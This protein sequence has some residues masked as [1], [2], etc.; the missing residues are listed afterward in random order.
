MMRREPARAHAAVFV[1]LATFL[2]VAVTACQPLTPATFVSLSGS[3]VRVEA[4]RAGG[5][6]HLGTGI[7]IAP[8]IIVT[9]CHV[10][11]DGTGIRIVGSGS[12]WDVTG[13]YADTLHDLCFLR[14]PE[15]K[16]SPVVLGTSEALHLGQ[17]VAALGFTGG[18]DIALKFGRVLALHSFDAGEVI[19]SDTAFTSGSSGGGLFD[20]GGALVGLLTFRSRGSSSSYYSVPVE[21]I[22]ERLPEESQWTEL[23][24]LDGAAPFWQG[25][26]ETLPYFLRVAPQAAK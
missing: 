7:T 3:V 4:G 17:P 24:P 20:A 18:M 9:N 1:G 15:W 12:V 14:A 22:R 5:G 21:W 6:L 10:T 13:Q 26:P 25:S 23:G 8:S 19:E 16:G 11:H 2:Y